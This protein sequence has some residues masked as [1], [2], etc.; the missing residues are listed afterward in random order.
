M[1]SKVAIYWS[2]KKAIWAKP[3]LGAI[4]V[5]F[6]RH[7]IKP[8]LSNY[9]NVIE[10]DLAV[11]WGHRPKH[12]INKQKGPGKD[13]LVMERGYIGD[14]FKW[15]SLGFNGLNGRGDFQ[16]TD[17]MPSD[18]WDK[19]FGDQWLKP[20][21][22]N[23]EY[24]LLIGQVAGDA[25]VEH[26]NFRNWAL[27]AAEK[28]KNHFDLRFRPHPIDVKRNSDYKI[29]GTI[30]S[31]RSLESDLKGAAA[32]I[33]FNSNTGVE[34][35]MAGVPT[36]ATDKGSMVYNLATNTIEEPK[37]LSGRK[38]WAYDMAYKQWNLEEIKNG[39]AWEHLKQ[40]FEK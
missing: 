26:I 9:R 28:I 39:L 30:H 13:Y 37:I 38:Q 31:V 19:Y 23:G 12:I 20:Q 15:T 3:W 34:S 14:R 35:V 11:F 2:N 36:V 4:E 10:C 22:N 6:L 40:R 17:D 21:R 24:I 5:G 7:G 25:S 27:E 1:L 33:T 8:E 29:P 32:V 16:I 18:R